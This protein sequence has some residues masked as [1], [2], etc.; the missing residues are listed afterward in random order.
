MLLS[1]FPAAAD[2]IQ[3]RSA[4]ER[5]DGWVHSGNGPQCEAAMS[6]DPIRMTNRFQTTPLPPSFREQITIRAGER[7][8]CDIFIDETGRY[9]ETGRTIQYYLT[10]PRAQVLISDET[11]RLPSMNRICPNFANLN[12]AERAHVWV[13][14]MAAIAWD[15]SKCGANMENPENPEADG[16]FQ[17]ERS[18]AGRRWR[19]FECAYDRR[20]Q[21]EDAVDPHYLNTQCAMRIM[22]NMFEGDHAPAN[23]QSERGLFPF[24]YWEQ[25]RPP[26][27]SGA[28]DSRVLS[29]M[30]EHPGC[31]FSPLAPWTSPRPE[32]RPIR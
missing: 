5:F 18:L 7:P 9:G 27:V 22:V 31:G 11:A 10:S 1:V 30:A 14:F 4:L 21:P 15:E 32:R 29:R 16:L 20:D 24:A 13:W 2:E 19:G 3:L 6:G 23:R 8:P 12:A 17:M 26:Y 25:L 28:D